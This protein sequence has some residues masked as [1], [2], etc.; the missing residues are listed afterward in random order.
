MHPDYILFGS[1]VILIGTV[2]IALAYVL[3]EK[4]VEEFAISGESLCVYTGIFS[5]FYTLCY[6]G[7][8]TVP[9]W[10]TLMSDQVREAGGSWDQIAF[11]FGCVCFFAYL[12]NISYFYIVEKIGSLT[13]GVLQSL[14]AVLVFYFSSLLYCSSHT[15]QC[16]TMGKSLSA[17]VVII[18]VVSFIVATSRKPSHEPLESV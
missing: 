14:R 11:V 6:M 13:A 10:E 12:H 1:F 18:G 4:I 5:S 7:V 8:Y 2:L 17:F 3:D 15:E 16:L 9:R